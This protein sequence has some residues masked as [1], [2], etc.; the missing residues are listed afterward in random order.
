LAKQLALIKN[1]E[2]IGFRDGFNGLV[3]DRTMDLSGGVLSGILTLGGTILG[4][5]RNIPQVMPTANGSA[6]LTQTRWIRISAASWTRWCAL[7]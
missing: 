4:I 6:D 3:E 1:L 7:G 5:S 2:L